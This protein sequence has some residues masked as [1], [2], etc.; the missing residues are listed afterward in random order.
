M[1]ILGPSPLETLQKIA[2]EA[3]EKGEAEVVNVRIIVS[4]Q[5]NQN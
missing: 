4:P 3:L 2:E 1:V 5:I